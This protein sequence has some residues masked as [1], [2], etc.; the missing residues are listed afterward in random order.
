MFC[1]EIE[2]KDGLTTERER[3]MRGHVEVHVGIIRMME[4]GQEGDD[5]RRVKSNRR[6]EGCSEAA[7]NVK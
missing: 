2:R 1:G 5:R 3:R 7:E 4:S 6:I